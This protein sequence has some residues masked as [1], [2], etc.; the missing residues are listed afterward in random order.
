MEEKRPKQHPAKLYLMVPHEFVTIGKKRHT[1]FTLLSCDKIKSFKGILPTREILATHFQ[2]E[3][4]Q[5]QMAEEKNKTEGKEEKYIPQPL[6]LEVESSIFAAIVEEAKSKDS[7]VTGGIL[8]LTLGGNFPCC[9][10]SPQAE[11]TV[12]KVNNE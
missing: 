1:S 4:V 9:L 10:I 2:A 3:K 12:R 6:Y 11:E 8:A 5:L 7:N